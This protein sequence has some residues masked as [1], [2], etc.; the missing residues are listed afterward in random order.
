MLTRFREESVAMMADIGSMFYQVRVPPKD[1]DFLCFPWWPEGDLNRPLEE[2][3]MTV[4]IFGATSSP[5]CA[6]FALRKT[7]EER[8][9]KTTVEAAKTIERNFYMDD[10]LTA[11]ASE[12]KA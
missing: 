10:C 4:H 3:R 5:C 1:S 11:V 7:A 6:C 8:S 12:K 9:N 2:Y